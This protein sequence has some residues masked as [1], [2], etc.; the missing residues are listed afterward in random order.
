MYT[1]LPYLGMLSLC[2]RTRLQE[3]INSNIISFCKVKIIIK[4][5]I[6]ILCDQPILNKNEASL[7]LYLFD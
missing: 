2:L 3:S 1:V 7:L 6:L 4:E 5:S